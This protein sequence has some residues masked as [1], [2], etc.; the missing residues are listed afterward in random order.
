MPLLCGAMHDEAPMNARVFF[1]F[2]VAGGTLAAT[3]RADD[4]AALEKR[5]KDLEAEVKKLQDAQPSQEPVVKTATK[6]SLALSGY[7]ETSYQWNFNQPD[8]LITNYR[9]FDDRHAT[10]LVQNVVLDALATYDRVSARLAVQFGETGQ[11]YYSAEP[12]WRG[13]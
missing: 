11:T 2:V 10:F 3:A 5:V 8:N 4:P 7:V 13:A 9:A 1:G 6:A 12:V